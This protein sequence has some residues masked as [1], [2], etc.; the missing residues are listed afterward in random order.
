M[1]DMGASQSLR[2]R[3]SASR[4]GNTHSQIISASWWRLGGVGRG[5]GSVVIRDLSCWS[6]RGTP[7]RRRGGAGWSAGISLAGRGGSRRGGGGGG[8][9]GGGDVGSDELGVDGDRDGGAFAR[10]GDDLRAGGG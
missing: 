2:R 8:A 6:G 10:G 9:G 7:R 4:V 1:V 3:L 5:G